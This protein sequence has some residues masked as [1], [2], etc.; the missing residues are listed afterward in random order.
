MIKRI[1]QLPVV[2]TSFAFREEYFPELEGMVASVK[3]HHPDWFI[4]TGKGPVKGFELPTLDVQS[5]LGTQQWSLP[6]PL[7]LDGS[8]N[9]WR[10]ITKMKAWWIARVWHSFG[11][12]AGDCKRILWIDADAWVNGPLEIELDPESEVIAGAWDSD[13]RQPGFEEVILSGFLLLQGSGS[14]TVE[15]ILKQWSDICLAHIQH[16]PNPPLVPDGDGDQEVLSQILKLHPCSNGDSILM[17]LDPDKYCAFVGRHGVPLA[18]AVVEQ[19]LL[20][21]KMKWPEHRERE[22]PPPED[23]RRRLR[24]AAL[25]WR[26]EEVSQMKAELSIEQPAPENQRQVWSI[27]IFSGETL[28]DLKPIR[29]IRMPVISA[30]EVSDIPAE[31]V[32]DPFMIKADGAWHMFF[33]VMNAE[34]DK[35]EIG[36]ATSKNGLQWEYQRIVLREPFHL[37]YPYVFS[38]NGEYFMIPES[39]EAKAMR[40]YRADPFPVRWSYVATLLDGPWV[41][42]SIFFFDGRWWVFTNPVDLDNRVLELFYA[43]AM[44]GP[45][46][47]HAMS[48]L[49]SGNNRM[50]RGGG[51]VIVLNDKPVRFTQDC[52]PTYGTSVRAFEVS[53]LTKSSYAERELESSPILSASNELW[54]QNGM[55]H[56]DPHYVGGRWFACVDGWRLEDKTPVLTKGNA[57]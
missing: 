18:G 46:R 28:S 8:W 37:S 56:I 11:H 16:L 2:L 50:A 52:F 26:N 14:R 41:D 4:V 49:I 19:W 31:F 53:V 25:N 47:R 13:P 51:R 48:P 10:K 12:L 5:P 24:A 17:V 35:G 36:L 29:G 42:S 20:S 44:K 3:E 6:V 39:F 7:N 45:W 55:H 38:N 22:W 34:R 57:Q 9:D 27:G 21:R 23:A 40:L 33:E 54:R 43:D 30:K 1:D 15:G 32:A